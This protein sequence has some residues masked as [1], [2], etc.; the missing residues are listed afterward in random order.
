MDVIYNAHICESDQPN[1]HSTALVM[2]AGSIVAVG[3]DQEIL[4]SCPSSTKKINLEGKTICPG[5]IDSHLHL[6]TYGQFLSQVDCETNTMQECLHRVADR[7]NQTPDGEWILGH[8]WNKNIWENGWGCA[9]DLDSVSIHHPVYLTDKALHSGWANSLALYRAGITAQTPD[10]QGGIIQRDGSGNPTGI[11][12]ENAVKLVESIIPQ[13]TETQLRETLLTAQQSLLSYGITAVCDFDNMRA[14]PALQQL[15]REDELLL[16]VCKGIPLLYLEDAINLHIK[17]G[18]GSDHLWYGPVK[19]FADGALGPQTAA[20]WEP[21]EGSESNFGTLLMT[22]EDVY[23]I[24]RRAISNGYSLAIHAIGDKAVDQV[25]EGYVRLREFERQNDLPYLYHRIEHLQ[26][27]RPEMMDKLGQL[28]IVA[29][30]QPIHATSDMQIADQH[31]G[32]RS[33]HAYKFNSILQIGA[34]MIFGSDAPVETPNPFMGI[35]AAVTRCRAQEKISWHAEERIT[36]RQ[37]LAAYTCAPA[38]IISTSVKIGRLKPGYKADLI[39][40]EK[41]PFSVPESEIFTIQ[42]ESVMVDGQWV[43]DNR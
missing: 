10:P 34:K 39:V 11:L 25:L 31:W 22:S 17:S 38:E 13:P 3:S 30:M 28:N 9:A 29:S 20:M 24:G 43:I 32:Q 27:L 12:F 16:R 26:M 1:P 8:G 41:D 7:A 21:Y 37:A 5:F 14:F 15:D 35:H 40:L 18:E 33:I 42:P 36:L 19:C 4:D 2:D 23:T 6:H